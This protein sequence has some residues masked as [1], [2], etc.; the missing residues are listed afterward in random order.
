MQPPERIKNGALWVRHCRRIHARAQDF[1]DGRLGVILAARAF[2]PLVIWTHAEADPDLAVFLRIDEESSSLPVGAVRERWAPHAL[3]PYDIKITSIEVKWQTA[4]W[5]A[6]TNLVRRYAW[7][8]EARRALRKTRP[9]DG[10][11]SN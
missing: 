7:A 4:A 10:L 11:S 1:L 2:Q 5:D 3:V 8:L 6:A 9:N